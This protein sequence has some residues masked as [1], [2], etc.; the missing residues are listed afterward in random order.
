MTQAH[1]AVPQP[2]ELFRDNRQQAIRLPAG[3]ELP[4]DTALLHREG[5]RLII[6]P[7]PPAG[8]LALL[9]TWQP[10]VEALPDIEETPIAPEDVF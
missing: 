10:M 6:E 1:N 7:L 8:L 3:V 2:V 4:G 5:G 9:A